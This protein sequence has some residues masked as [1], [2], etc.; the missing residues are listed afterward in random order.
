MDIASHLNLL[1]SIFARLRTEAA[2]FTPLEWQ[3]PGAC[4][5]WTVS[6]VVAH[7]A[8]GAQRYT[9]WIRRALDGLAEPPPGSAFDPDLATGS[10]SIK[11]R[12]LVYH[13]AVADDVLGSF[14]AA[15]TEFIDLV[16]T[17]QPDDWHR[18]AFHPSG[19][20][21]VVGLLT[22]RIAELSLHRWDILHA[23]G[24]E[25]HLPDG[26][27]EALLD[28][29]PRW[30]AVGFRPAAPLARPLRFDFALAAPI[31][32]TVGVDIHGECFELRSEPAEAPDA[33]FTVDPERFILALAGRLSLA[34]ALR[35]ADERPA[36][37]AADFQRW[38]GAL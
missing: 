9:L 16:E 23:L 25:A 17:L 8:Q 3:T 4:G 38:F 35:A 10:A 1:R 21:P 20:L 2:A 12:T 37:A 31:S 28:W 18:P 22:W 30:L 34:A 19:V 26:S 27:H 36:R 15:T 32:R 7:L 13:Q 29:L 6:Q 5:D 14:T 33:I 11:E 24:R